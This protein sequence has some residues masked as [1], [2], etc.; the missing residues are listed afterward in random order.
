M[1]DQDENIE[2]PYCT[3]KMFPEETIHCIEWAKD[4]F[5]NTFYYEPNRF[6]KFI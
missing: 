6:N 1:K 5:E 4:L 2:I 3:I